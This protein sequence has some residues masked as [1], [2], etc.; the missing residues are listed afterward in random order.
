MNT[1]VT[2]RCS[3]VVDQEA[4]EVEILDIVCKVYLTASFFVCLTLKW[5]PS[6]YTFTDYIHL[7][8]T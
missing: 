2:Y 6:P 3:R 1:E 8:E 5:F 7:S 4:V